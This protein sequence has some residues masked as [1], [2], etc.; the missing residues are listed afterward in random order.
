[1]QRQEQ[2]DVECLQIRRQR[3]TARQ[4]S[5]RDI[6]IVV[7][8]GIKNPHRCL[9]GIPRHD[10]DF[11]KAL[12]MRELVQLQQRAHQREAGAE[13]EDFIFIVDLVAAVGLQALI[14]EN[15]LLRLEVEQ[16]ARR[17]ANHQQVIECYGH[18]VKDSRCIGNTL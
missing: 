4:Y 11:D 18:G 6:E 7:F 12:V 17:N 2:A 16:R 10:D 3:S 13:L 9:R 5:A 8:D 14:A 15:G 1:M